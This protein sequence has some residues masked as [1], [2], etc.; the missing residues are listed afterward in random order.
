MKLCICCMPSW[1]SER[2]RCFPAAKCIEPPLL[3]R[4]LPHLRWR[5]LRG[6]SLEDT[7][8]QFSHTM[9]AQVRTCDDDNLVC[10]VWQQY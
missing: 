3:P 9:T 5:I 10:C 7:V 8:S 2:C 6:I 1:S 4:P